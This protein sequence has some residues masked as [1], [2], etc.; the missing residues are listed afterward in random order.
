MRR[1]AEVGRVRAAVEQPLGVGGRTSAPTR[2][3]PGR[4][5]RR[6]PSRRS[7]RRSSEFARRASAIACERGRRPRHRRRARGA[8]LTSLRPAVSTQRT[9]SA[10]VASDVRGGEAAAA[11]AASRRRRTRSRAFSTPGAAARAARDEPGRDPL[12]ALPGLRSRRAASSRRCGGRCRRSGRRPRRSR[13]DR[14]TGGERVAQQVGLDRRR[15]DRALPLEDRGDGEA[16]RL[17][18]LRRPDHDHR[19]ARLGGDEVAVDAAER[20]PSGLRRAD[21]QRAEIARLRPARA[22]SA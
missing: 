20:E 17:A 13:R 14:A 18:G 15:D 1:R 3:R 4:R 16:G 19:L 6:A 22:G 2:A 12:R 5:R 21:A 10:I 7:R 8:S 11:R 9:T